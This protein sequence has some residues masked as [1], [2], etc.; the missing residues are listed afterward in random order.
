LPQS[1][2][3]IAWRMACGYRRKNNIDEI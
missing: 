1:Q 2:I 3:N